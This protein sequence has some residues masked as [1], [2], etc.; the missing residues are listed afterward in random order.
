[1][2]L[3]FNHRLDSILN[4]E[5]SDDYFAAVGVVQCGDR[6]LLGLARKTD[7]DRTGKWVF[8]GGGMKSKE[9]PEQAAVREVWEETGIRCSAAGKAFRCGKK[10]VAFVHCK[11]RAG[12]K[13]DNNHEFSALG[14]FTTREMRSLKLYHNVLKL[15]ERVK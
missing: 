6:W 10:G 3:D 15:I 12:Q 8:P 7:D 11:A 13:F 4:E 1:M 14:W 5:F 2:L 9:T